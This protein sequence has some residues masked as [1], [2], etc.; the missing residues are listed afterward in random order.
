MMD[1]K[2]AAIAEEVLSGVET[3]R[4]DIAV[5]VSA[6]KAALWDILYWANR[7]REKFFHNKVRVC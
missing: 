6:D 4:D 7:I 2:I 1:V 5:L 3:T